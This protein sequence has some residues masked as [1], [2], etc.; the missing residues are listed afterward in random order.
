MKG[1][2]HLIRAFVAKVDRDDIDFDE[3]LKE[4]SYY[5][6][7]MLMEIAYEVN[8]HTTCLRVDEDID[9]ANGPLKTMLPLFKKWL[10]PP[11][12]R[13]EDLVIRWLMDICQSN[14]L[15]QTSAFLNS[16]QCYKRLT[17]SC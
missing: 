15:F 13:G 16:C 7:S 14:N 5:L 1:I 4:A 6:R 11:F 9:D 2:K 12:Y 3:E 10:V 17:L 8:L